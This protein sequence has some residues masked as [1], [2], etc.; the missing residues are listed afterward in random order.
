VPAPRPGTRTPTSLDEAREVTREL[1][2]AIKDAT[3]LKREY[4]AIVRDDRAAIQLARDKLAEAAKGLDEA[5]IKRVA[6]V[7]ELATDKSEQVILRKAKDLS[8]VFEEAAERIEQKF[9]EVKDHQ[10]ALMGCKNWDD[11]IDVVAGVALADI[12]AALRRSMSDELPK[13]LA[14]RLAE[15]ERVLGGLDVV[16]ERRRKPGK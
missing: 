12:R 9:D 10:A 13:D 3:A 1:H 15:G 4:Q 16:L 8:A 5:V 14:N 11:L 2:E 6:S 7:L